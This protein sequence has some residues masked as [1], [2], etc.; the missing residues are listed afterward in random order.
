[1]KKLFPIEHSDLEWMLFEAAGFSI[2][3]SGIVSRTANSPCCGLPL[4]GIST[5]CLDIDARGVFGFSTL[6]NPKSVAWYDEKRRIP[7]KLPKIEPILG[8]AVGERTWVL[9]TH[10]ILEGGEIPWCT[11]PH[12]HGKD[13]QIQSVHSAQIEGV[14]PPKEI[15]YWGH[16]PVADLEFETDAPVSVGLRAW[17][18]FVPG[19]IA[20]SNI[21]AAIF[22]VHL[23]NK[24][25]KKQTGT[26]A[27]NFPGPD[28]D[29]ARNTEF[30]RQRIDE[31]FHGMLVSSLGDVQ[32]ILGVIGDEKVRFGSGLS[33][34]PT[35]WAEIA[36]ALP[37][38]TWRPHQGG[39]L[40]QDSSCS[41]AVDFAL[42]KEQENVIRF[43]LTWYAPVWEGARNNIGEMA[44]ERHREHIYWLSPDWMGDTN[45]YTQMYAARYR[46][47]IDVARHVAVEHKALLKSVLAWQEVVYAE[48][49]LPTW[50]KDS[51]VNNLAL[52]AEDSHWA[53]P[54]PP[55]G[56]WAFPHG[57]FALNESPR[58]CPQ[59]AC[60][61]CDWYGNLPIVFFF[62]SLALS[63]LRAF[64]QYQCEDGEIPFALG[65][66]F[67]LPDMAT[68]RYFWQVALNGTCYVDMVD[69]LWQRTG[70]DNVLKEFYDSVKKCNTFTMNLRK[71]PGGVISMP[72]MGGM[73]WFEHGE[74]AGMAA[75]MGGLRLAQLSMMTRMA[76]AMSDT[77]YVKQC[78]EWLEDG[79]RAMEEEMW[80]GN[81]YLNF[82]EKETGKK[83][84]DVMAYQLDG[85][86]AAKY[87]GISSVFQSERVKTTLETIRQCNIALTPEIGAANF[88]RPDGKPL[89]KESRVA[90]Y[91]QY[92]MFP[93][94]LL[95]L[96]MT[97]MYSGEKTFG[98]ELARRHWANLILTQ[99]HP[100][101]LPNIVRGD[102]GER[103]FGTDYYQN[104]LL[105]ALPAALLEEDLHTSVQP[106]SL[107]ERVIAA[108]RR[109]G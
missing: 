53:Q 68:P 98:L 81:Y 28:S 46:S 4:G 25:K 105:W 77:E 12:F 41:I 35:A 91:G 11:E 88:A 73:E 5:G 45:F 58:G 54:K 96:A 69:R 36:K 85:E 43:L 49:E 7:R 100:W 23:R 80:A 2:P 56:D 52:I 76:E 65:K 59:I 39:D 38:P 78:Q 8:L 40:Y 104:M 95:V 33:S 83:S 14:Y 20:A 102:T 86:W 92:A 3:V 50:L 30:T 64:K 99:R 108:G 15:Y 97:Y 79:T 61:P 51:L 19:D 84:D 109:N 75:H 17:A 93:P 9:A 55:L 62:P 31:D 1:M 94:E 101:D 6:F 37:E 63:T 32:Y 18:P 22:E 87:H 44:A 71:G 48:N 70:D 74:W 13:T 21:P 24:S 10:D 89:P 66:I 26:I 60:I 107:V 29:E 106:G 103:V 34:T 82:Y 16:Y 57:V 90:A 27:F 67:D 72:E 47:A 42:K